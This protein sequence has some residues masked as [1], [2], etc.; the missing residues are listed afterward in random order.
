MADEISGAGEAI[1]Q[2]HD[3]LRRIAYCAGITFPQLVPL[4]EGGLFV[5]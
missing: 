3:L 1:A 5:K 4:F 2:I